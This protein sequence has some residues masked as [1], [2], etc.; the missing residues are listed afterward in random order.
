MSTNCRIGIKYPNEKI[1][2]IYCHWDGYPS[3]V[4]EVL[5]GHYTDL[6]KISELIK[7][8][9]I[10]SLGYELG[11]SSGVHNFDNKIDGITVFYIRDR[12]EDPQSCKSKIVD[13]MDD[14]KQI[15]SQEYNYIYDI[16]NK[17]W[18]TYDS[19]GKEI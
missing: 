11:S 10:S 12:N 2:S 3:Y 1:E 9:D 7:G 4:G 19:E 17:K 18:I 16:I 13:N 15:L 5:K 8:G 6:S 14:F